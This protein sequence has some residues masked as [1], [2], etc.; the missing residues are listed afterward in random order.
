[1][2]IASRSIPDLIALA[3][4][5]FGLVGYPL[6]APLMGRQWLAAEMFG[7]APDPT[8]LATLALLSLADGGGRW[9][10]SIIPLIWCVITGLTLWA[11]E[12]DDF[13]LRLLAR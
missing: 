11:M 8:A 7:L 13:L 9:P 3:L 12:A 2:F 4:F 10:L 1:M 5:C 6:L